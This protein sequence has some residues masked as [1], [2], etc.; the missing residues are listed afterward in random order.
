MTGYS[1]VG[2]G[3]LLLAAGGATAAL[4]GLIF[5]ALSINIHAVLDIDKRAGRNFLTGRALKALVALLGI[6]CLVL[7]PAPGR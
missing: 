3:E 2:W 1:T 6:G 4:S 5:G 7:L